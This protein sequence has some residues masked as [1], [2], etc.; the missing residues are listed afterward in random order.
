[1]GGVVAKTNKQPSF[2]PEGKDYDYATARAAGMGPDGTGEDAGH[3]GSVAPASMKEKK[4]FD[5]PK[6]S[7]KILKG[8]NHETWQKAID[9][10]QERGFEIKK[11]GN[12]Y[13]S[14]PKK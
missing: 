7:Y 1:M 14:I 5:L 6:E 12:R 11:Y 8:R 4:E 10:E 2:D 13:F 3:W 9:A